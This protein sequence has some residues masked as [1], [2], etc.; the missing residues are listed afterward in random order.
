MADAAPGRRGVAAAAL[1]ILRDDVRATLRPVQQRLTPTLA[2]VLRDLSALAAVDPVD[3]VEAMLARDCLAR[4]LLRRLA[5]DEPEDHHLAPLEVEAVVRSMFDVAARHCPDF[6]TTLHLLGVV[7]ESE[8]E[9]PDALSRLDRLDAQMIATTFESWRATK[10]SEVD[11]LFAPPLLDGLELHRL[12]RLRQEL[13]GRLG[14]ALTAE[15]LAAA[16]DVPVEKATESLRW[17]SEQVAT[18]VA[19]AV[20]MDDDTPTDDDHG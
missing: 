8:T 19:F 5:A 15:E 18:G 10:S 20:P 12:L 1:T 16:A 4:D 7:L 11:E 3:V 14:R 2:A 17:N 6:L 13:E 9:L